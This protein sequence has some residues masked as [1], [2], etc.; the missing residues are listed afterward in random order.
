MRQMAYGGRLDFVVQV[1]LKKQVFITFGV[2]F[3]S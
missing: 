2:E 3:G 1:P